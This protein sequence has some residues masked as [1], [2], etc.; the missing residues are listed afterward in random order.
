MRRLRRLGYHGLHGEGQS[1]EHAVQAANLTKTFGEF[2]AVA[3]V[4]FTVERG[5]I[6]GFLGPNGAGKTTA[7]RI[8][9]GFLR[10]TGGRALVYGKDTW[11]RSA[12]NRARIG[13]LPGD[14]RLYPNLTGGQTV[15]F[16]AGARGPGGG[17][18]A[19][20]LAGRFELD[21]GVRV[22]EYS[23]GMRS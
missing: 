19:E 13:Y 18:D 2:T 22:R 6:F 20:R 7:I 8:L 3:G 12:E 1:T 15:R 23:K 21:L 11:R 16:F 4:S 10:P 9:L 14:I 5:A 17:V